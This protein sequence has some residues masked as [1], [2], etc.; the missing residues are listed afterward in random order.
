M[1]FLYAVFFSFLTI[2]LS[3]DGYGRE[4]STAERTIYLVINNKNR[5]IPKSLNLIIRNTR[6]DDLSKPY[7]FCLEIDIE[8]SDSYVA[9]LVIN[10][11]KTKLGLYIITKITSP[12]DDWYV[13]GETMKSLVL[14]LKPSSSYSS[15]DNSIFEINLIPDGV[16][17]GGLVF[18]P[19]LKK[20]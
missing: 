13:Y 5:S 1:N 12:K 10:A 7:H 11:D 17:E 4:T 20:S 18:R 3:V 6:N 8:P 14:N 9:P 15:E 2:V 19:R 16:E